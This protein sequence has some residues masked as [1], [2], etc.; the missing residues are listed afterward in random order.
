MIILVSIYSFLKIL[1]YYMNDYLTTQIITYMGN[2]RKLLDKIE[3]V[4]INLEKKEGKKLSI[5]DGF[6]GSG[7]VSRL[8]KR[9]ADKL[10][11]NDIAD[12]SE[13]LNKCFLNNI[14]DNEF[15]QIKKYIDTANR[16]ADKKTK[17]I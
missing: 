11:T 2:K 15:N 9:H 8:F 4:L 3:N 5:G 6:S 13:T 10:Y 1:Y 14:S 7:I 16:H 17:K 12:Y